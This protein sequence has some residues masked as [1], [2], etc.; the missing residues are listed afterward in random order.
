MEND[1]DCPLTGRAGQG[2]CSP[3]EERRQTSIAGRM[4]VY[5]LAHGC[6]L[7]DKP[8]P[9]NGLGHV[10]LDLLVLPDLVHPKLHRFHSTASTSPSN[11]FRA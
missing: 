8:Q 10:S 9:G 4:T 1:G 6:S 2:A 5:S 7:F 11:S 3:C